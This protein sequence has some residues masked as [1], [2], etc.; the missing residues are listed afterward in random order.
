MPDSK[1]LPA[2]RVPTIPIVESGEDGIAVTP[3]VDLPPAEKFGFT[4]PENYPGQHNLPSSAGPESSEIEVSEPESQGSKEST[5]SVIEKESSEHTST[6]DTPTAGNTPLLSPSPPRLSRA[7]SM[8]V[9]SQLGSLNNPHRIISPTSTVDTYFNPYSPLVL[10][11]PPSSARF[12]ELSLE[13]ADSVQMVVQTLLQISPPH[14]LDPAKEQFAACSLSV[15]SPSITAMLTALKNLNYMSA[16]MATFAD[17]TMLQSDPQVAEKEPELNSATLSEDFDIGEVLQSVGDALSGLAAQAGVELVLYHSDVGMRHVSVHGDECGISYALSHIIRQILETSLPGDTIEIG[18]SISPELS[19]STYDHLSSDGES[20][21]SSRASSSVNDFDGPLR[22]TFEV[23]HK[24][25]SPNTKL[26]IKNNPCVGAETPLVRAQPRLNSVIFRRLLARIRGTVK[27]DLEPRLFTPGRSCTLSVVLDSGSPDLLTNPP[28]LSAEEA[29]LRQ[30]YANINLQLASEPCLGELLQ[31]VDSLKGKKVTLHASVDGSFAHHLT[32]YLTTWGLD[33]SHVSLSSSENTVPEV[34][35]ENNKDEPFVGIQADLSS[36]VELN[37]LEEE[38]QKP[39]PDDRPA[40]III[41]DDV[42]SLRQRLV[43][44][45]AESTFNLNLRRPQLAAHHR[46]VSSPQIYRTKAFK[47]T[48]SVAQH[49]VQHPVIL[50]FT[51]LQNFK[52]VKD[53]IHSVMSTPSTSN[54]VPEVIVLPKPAG[55]RRVLTALRTAMIKPVVDPFFTPIATSPLSPSGLGISPFS[56]FSGSSPSQRPNRPPI[57][58]RTASERSSRT[59]KEM[60]EGSRLPPSPLRDSEIVG[61]YFEKEARKLGTSPSSGLLIQSLDGQPAGIFFNPQGP[62][63]AKPEQIY[64]EAMVS[65][66]EGSD[67]GDFYVR[68]KFLQRRLT[69]DVDDMSP[70]E[71]PKPYSKVSGYNRYLRN[72]FSDASSHPSKS[73][74]EL[75]VSQK[76]KVADDGFDDVP[77]NG[78][79]SDGRKTMSPPTSPSANRADASGVSGPTRRPRKGTID[80]A[81]SPISPQTKRGKP[82][83]GNIVV[84]PVNVLIVE[85][86]P[87]NQTILSTFMKKKKIKYDVAINGAE[88]VAKWKTGGFHLILMD[89]QMPVMDGIEATKEIRRLE[90]Q[91][92]STPPLDGQ[93]TPSESASSDSKSISVHTPFKSSVII[94]ALTA[95]SLQVDRVAALAAGCNDFLTKPVSLLWLNNKIIEWGSIKA[96]QMWADF[97]P[98]VMRSVTSGQVNQAKAVASKLHVPEGRRTPRKHP[99]DINSLSSTMD[100]MRILSSP[101]RLTASRDTEPVESE[102]HP[103]VDNQAA[104]A[105]N[106]KTASAEHTENVSLSVTSATSGEQQ[107]ETE[108]KETSGEGAQ[109]AG[110]AETLSSVVERTTTEQLIGPGEGALNESSR[111]IAEVSNTDSTTPTTEIVSG[112]SEDKNSENNGL[113]ENPEPHEQ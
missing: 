61:D 102:N 11:Q 109:L 13:L 23:G 112:T 10:A 51:G 43:Q 6:T 34:S 20:R 108:T 98:D 27:T 110:S 107:R 5:S 4:Y 64:E 46:P 85:D 32:S 84:P 49:H 24:F 18:L 26:S 14:L 21:S 113:S 63:S 17:D 54:Y 80:S 101:T 66:L 72:Y 65:S 93:H 95:S 92:A 48:F 1:V 35:I 73:R 96:L 41:D 83:D 77:G 31:F 103:K 70:G 3:I 15:P 82:S 62:R 8:P 25:V 29:A 91:S 16:N 88:A 9:S 75:S 90:R 19:V 42:D 68:R 7:F 50:H 89:I 104:N 44:M 59:P 56:P 52:L 30:P 97:R 76:A 78:M 69:A 106:Q 57:S 71:R 58:P 81:S 94:V 2:V 67:I 28:K 74:E 33:V 12:R 105:A 45:R 22:C 100:T 47:S 60:A 55:P 99:V 38:S 86:N 53:L 37:S 79:P 87:I 36:G 40:F 39:K 111:S